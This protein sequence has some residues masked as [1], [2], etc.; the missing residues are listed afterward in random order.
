MPGE[1]QNQGT[2]QLAEEIA[3][4]RQATRDLLGSLYPNLP[5]DGWARS[6]PASWKRLHE[7][8]LWSTIEPPDGSL[9]MA[10][11]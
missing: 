1:T 11:V 3:L 10:L 4:L 6:W 5:D 2:D 8:G 7:H 9:T